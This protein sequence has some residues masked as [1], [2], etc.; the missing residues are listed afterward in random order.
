MGNSLQPI[1]QY[2]LAYSAMDSRSLVAMCAQARHFAPQ[3]A[4]LRHCGAWYATCYA[5]GMLARLH[6]LRKRDPR[7]AFYDG[8][9]RA[10]TTNHGVDNGHANRNRDTI[11]ARDPGSSRGSRGRMDTEA[12]MRL[13][14]IYTENK[15]RSKVEEI[16]SAWFDAYTILEATGYWK[17]TREPSLILEFL[18]DKA[19]TVRV[20]AQLIKGHN[21]QEAVLVV[22]SEVDSE[23]V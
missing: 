9:I 2:I 10:S 21:V 12:Q 22:S 16:A 5:R 20:V 7:V 4:I 8:R 14:R 19:S 1:A 11:L 3:H 17:G 18:T 15:N 23:L 13:Y 6:R